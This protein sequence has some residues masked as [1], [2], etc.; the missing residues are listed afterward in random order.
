ME[1]S[2]LIRF[3]SLRKQIKEDYKSY[4]EKVAFY[5]I[6]KIVSEFICEL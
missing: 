5:L 6:L 3:S 2:F 1:K 4:G